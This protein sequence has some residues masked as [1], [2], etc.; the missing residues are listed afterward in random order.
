MKPTQI[1]TNKWRLSV[2]MTYRQLACGNP[3]KHIFEKWYRSAL[4]SILTWAFKFKNNRNLHTDNRKRDEK[5]K[6]TP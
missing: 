1:I 4:Y 5:N 6:I 3:I 2:S